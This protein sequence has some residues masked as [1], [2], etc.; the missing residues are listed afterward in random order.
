MIETS[1]NNYDRFIVNL[2][3]SVLKSSQVCL[4][5]VAK[6]FGRRRVV[7]LDK[8]ER[9]IDSLRLQEFRFAVLRG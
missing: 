2:L 5:A 1:R 3:T 8:E 7:G 9:D 6:D 4:R